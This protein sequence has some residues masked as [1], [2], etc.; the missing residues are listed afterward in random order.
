MRTLSTNGVRASVLLLAVSLAMGSAR[1]QTASASPEQSVDVV[2]VGAGTGGVSAA[3]QAARLGANVAVLEET[4]WVGGQMT[5]AADGTMNEGPISLHS[6]L[7][8]EFLQRMNSYYLI[9]GKSVGTCYWSDKRHCYDPSAIQK[10]LL[11]MIDDV[12]HEGK[13]QIKLYL[14]EKVV[15]ALEK[16][17]VVSGVI[18]EKHHVFHSKVVIDATELGDVL[19]LTT[20]AYRTGRFTSE[21]PGKS[22]IQDITYS[23]VIK[24]YLNGMPPELLMRH[25]PPGYDPAFVALIRRFLRSDG[26]PTRKDIPV[27]F[28][29][30]NASRGLPDKSNPENYTGATPEKITRT[31]LNFI[32]DYQTDTDL[33]DRSK[34]ESIYCAAKLKTLDLLYYIQHELKETSW[35]IA[36]DE[37]YDTPYNREEN[38]CP[39]IPQEF[40]AIEVNFPVLPYVRESRRLI[41]EYTVVGGDIRREVPWPYRANISDIDPAPIF[42]DA[43]AVG[44]F[45][46]YLHDC[47]TEADYEHDLEHATDMPRET[48]DGPFQIPMESFIPEKV[49]GL[50]AAEKNISQSRMVGSATRVQPMVMMTGQAAGALAAIAALQNIQPR[51]VDPGTVQRALLDFNAGL[52]KQELTDMPRNVEEWRAAE[53]ALVH[54]WISAVP[55]GFAPKQLMTRTQAADALAA[56]FKLFPAA[57][58]MDRRWGYQLATQASFKDVPLY[59]K[60]SPSIEAL[61]GVHAL[62]PCANGVDLFCPDDTET[63]ADFISS[64]NVLTQRSGARPPIRSSE[65]APGNANEPLTRVRAAELLYRYLDPALQDPK[66]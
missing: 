7:Y 64:L 6:G 63:V 39:N 37:G 12:N 38:S 33:F 65:Q 60:K 9:R 58:A 66:R 42:G 52:A 5:A 56:A 25:A 35:S 30:H 15:T 8:A 55:E 40:K 22:C 53:F 51:N 31:L 13:G 43:I 11:E 46:E 62:R 34:R 41:G 17:H 21:H 28:V 4:D 54:S 44:D 2:V 27:N 10:V 57:T 50:L 61:A 16:Q 20:A 23:A 29:M 18:T 32:N 1:A 3:L 24:K 45:T 48:R 26:D 14:R 19:P 36:N 59:S 49:D 47:S